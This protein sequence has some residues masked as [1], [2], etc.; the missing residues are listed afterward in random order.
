ME[1]VREIYFLKNSISSSKRYLRYLRDTA[2]I[3]EKEI[4]TKEAQ[5]RE[6]EKEMG[7]ENKGNG[8]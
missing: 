1:R 5:L 3:I 2:E 7:N 6:L 4:E 8:K